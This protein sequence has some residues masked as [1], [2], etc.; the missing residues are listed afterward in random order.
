MNIKRKLSLLALASF[1]VLPATAAVAPAAAPPKVPEYGF[2]GLKRVELVFV[3]A[4]ASGVAGGVMPQNASAPPPAPADDLAGRELTK[5]SECQ[6]IPKTLS[7]AG[8]E[9]V[10]SC[11]PDDAACAQLYLIV[12]NHSSDRIAERIYLV[13]AELSQRVKLV[14]D[15]KVD[16]AM[17]STWSAYRVA[18]VAADHSATTAACIDLRGLATWFGSSWKL[19]NK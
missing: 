12:E 2:H 17:P 11:K 7:N 15:K 9:I 3:N 1:L 5:D 13:G 14:R 8:L 10:K 6:A 4:G 18:V 19:A 16:L